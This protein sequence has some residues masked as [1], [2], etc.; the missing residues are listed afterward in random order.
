[1][2][3]VFIGNVVFA[4]GEDDL[5]QDLVNVEVLMEAKNPCADSMEFLEYFAKLQRS[6]D[7]NGKA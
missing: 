5:D 2:C 4:A 3:S 1:M 6:H 7:R